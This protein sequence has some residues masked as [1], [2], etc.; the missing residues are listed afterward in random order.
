MIDEVNTARDVALLSINATLDGRSRLYLAA[1]GETVVAQPGFAVLLA[2]NPGLV[3]ATD[4]PDAWHSRFPA[5]LEVTSNWAALAQLGAPASLVTEAMR[6]DRQRI[7]GEDGLGWTPQFRDIESLWRMSRAGRRA[8]RARILRLQ[9]PR[10][11]KRGQGSG[12][13]GG[14][15]L[16]D[17]R[18]GRLWPLPRR[19]DQ[20]PAQPPRLPAGGHLMSPR[21]TSGRRPA[22]FVQQ[23]HRA[24]AQRGRLDPVYQDL[25]DHWTAILQRLYPVWALIGP[26]LSDP[27]HIEIHSRTVYLDADA[28]LGPREAIAAG[29]LEQ[30]A[31]LR[32]FGVALHETLHA[33]HTKRWAIEHDVAL[34]EFA[35]TRPTGSSRSTGGCSRS[36]G[37]KRTGSAT[38]HPDSLRGRFVRRALQAAVVDVI[39]PAFAEQILAS[40]AAGAAPSRD[41]AA[42]ST[43]YLQARTLYGVLDSG[44]LDPLRTVWERVLGRDD[45]AALDQLYASVIWIPDGDLERLDAAAERYREIVGEPEQPPEAAGCGEPNSSGEH[46]DGRWRRRASDR[47]YRLAG[48]ARRRAR[49]GDRHRPRRAT[50]AARPRHRS[51]P[52]AARRGRRRPR[53]VEA[54]AGP[55]H[56]ASDRADA[57]PRSR[58]PAVPGRGTARSPLRQPAAPGDDRRHP[59]DRQAHARRAVRRPRLRARPRRA[60]CRTT[61]QHAPLADHP[62]G[63]RPDP[64][65]ARRADHRHLGVDGRLRVR[66]RSDR[67]DP[68]RRPAAGRRPLRDRRCSATAPSCSP[69][70]ADRCR[71]CLGS[72]P[73]AGPRSPATRSSSSQT[74]SR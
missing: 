20:R 33:K 62:P 61:G 54:R 18:P 59:A 40:F 31:I 60:S 35:T 64:G 50:R 12:R 63:H 58:P 13:R 55:R 56:R 42:R 66:A 28:L 19:R 65:A 3:G 6:L 25:S 32:T 44:V 70:A 41:L 7:A 45:V 22:V 21:T 4:I 16:P 36:H 9:P 71:S 34:A 17:A 15:R 57:R 67:L 1:T 74:S 11:G 26:G 43:A 51:R 10:A 53:R 38:S 47:G 5:T 2:Y 73:A 30:R 37:W 8:R 68:H 49:A 72:G 23:L 29:V 52:S 46:C 27:G 48:L 69:T 24:A 39:L 14:G